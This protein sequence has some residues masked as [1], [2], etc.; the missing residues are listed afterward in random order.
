MLIASSP[1][2]FAELFLFVADT[3]PS[4]ANGRMIGAFE[5]ALNHQTRRPVLG[6]RRSNPHPGNT[7]EDQH[8]LHG[9]R[10]KVLV[11]P[12][13]HTPKSCQALPIT[14]EPRILAAEPQGNDG[15]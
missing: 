9:L 5:A 2:F 11:L 8:E 13:G 14:N 12:L 7:A 15:Q 6:H 4:F 1:E 10:A 3:E